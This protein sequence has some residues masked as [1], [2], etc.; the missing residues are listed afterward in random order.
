MVRALFLASCWG[1]VCPL[2][3]LAH[4]AALPFSWPFPGSVPWLVLSPEPVADPSHHWGHRVWHLPASP[5]LHPWGIPVRAPGQVPDP[6]CRLVWVGGPG[7]PQRQSLCW[8]GRGVTLRPHPWGSGVLPACGGQSALGWRLGGR[9]PT[10]FPEPEVSR[11]CCL[12]IS[13]CKCAPRFGE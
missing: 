9:T 12:F 13:S 4:L 11:C 1:H 5:S 6:L 7:P 8:G 3:A 10:C 2:R